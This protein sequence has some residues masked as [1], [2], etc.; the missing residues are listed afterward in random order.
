MKGYG[1]DGGPSPP[2]IAGVTTFLR[3]PHVTQFDGVDVAVVGL[4]FDTGLAVRTGARFGPR[5]VRE[6][7]LTIHPAYNPVQRVAVFERLSVVDAGDVRAVAGGFTDRS[8]A[9]METM[10]AQIHGAGAVPLGIGGDH[11]VTLA[12]LRAAAARFGPLALLH[13]GAHTDCLDESSGQRHIHSTVIRRA[14]EE[15]VVDASRS[16]LLGMRGGLDVPDEYEQARELGFTVVPW[17]DLAQLGTGI[18]AAAVDAIGGAKAFVT[19]DVDFLDPGFAPAVGT[20]EVGGPDLG[21]GAGAHP[22]LPRP[23]PRRR[24]RRGGGARARQQ[25]PHGHRRRDHRLRAALADGLLGRGLRVSGGP[26]AGSSSAAGR[27][28]RVACVQLNT[29]GDVAAN[30]RAALELVEAAADQGARLI[31]LPETWAFKGRREGIIAT[32]EAPDGPSNRALAAAAARRGAWLLAGSVYEPAP[33]G[34]VANVSAL[35][36]PSGDLQAV[37][38]KIHLFDVTSGAVRYE[39]SEEVAPG[40]DVVTA[41]IDTAG[42]ASVR[43]GMSICYD[44]RF[45]GLYSSLALRGAQILC[46][47]SAFTAY[48]GAAHWE[49][50][51]RA[52]AIENGCFVIAPDQAGE[53]LPG[54]DCFGHSMI[55]DPWGVVLARLGEGTGVCVADLD[56]AR[57][58]EVRAQVPSLEH[59]RPDLYDR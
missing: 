2:R 53:H 8:L 45:P 40:A 16:S 10:L 17:D 57:L 56:L 4:P 58:D 6:A 59:R 34:L 31:A 32:A 9:A 28:L 5:A 51:L 19:V 54:R 23:G 15:G 37:Y 52:R 43:L 50:L 55:V 44:L 12:E 7:S 35:F 1:P 36:D 49:V 20:P 25:P 26:D 14:A 48:T 29:R 18:V 22:R 46:V 38:R 11:T 24:R 13:F 27:I 3:L 41:D 30:V 33:G 21:A 42:G 47:P 39:E